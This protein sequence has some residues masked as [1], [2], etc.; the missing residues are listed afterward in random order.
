M[1]LKTA[2]TTEQ[3][4]SKQKR[5]FL[6]SLSVTLKIGLLLKKTDF[7]F[8]D[9]FKRVLARKVVKLAIVQRSARNAVT[10]FLL[11]V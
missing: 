8:N 9:F 7:C 2:D 1:K 5:P 6:N 4:L 11:F 10:F 3:L